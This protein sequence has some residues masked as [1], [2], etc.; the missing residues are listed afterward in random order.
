MYA[1][2]D[3]SV[4]VY[5]KTLDRPTRM[6]VVCA[7]DSM[8]LQDCT[9]DSAHYGLVYSSGNG[10][11]H[12]AD[13]AGAK[14]LDLDFHV[15]GITGLYVGL[16]IKDMLRNRDSL[17]LISDKAPQLREV[18]IQEILNAATDDSTPPRVREI[19]SMDASIQPVIAGAT[20]DGDGRILVA[21]PG[22]GSLGIWDGTS[23]GFWRFDATYLTDATELDCDSTSV[24][25]PGA[26]AAD[27]TLL[28]V[29]SSN[30]DDL[31]L[32][33]LS[34]CPECSFV[35][36]SSPGSEGWRSLAISPDT[37]AGRFVYAVSGQGDVR[38]FSVEDATECLVHPE[39]TQ[40]SS[41]T[42]DDPLRFCVPAGDATL[43]DTAYSRGLKPYYSSVV[44]DLTFFEVHP[45]EHPAMGDSLALDGVYAALLGSDGSI[46]IVNVY[47]NLDESDWSALYGPDADGRVWPSQVVSHWFHNARNWRPKGDGGEDRPMIEEPISYYIDNA[48]IIP[49]DS[50]PSL[51]PFPSGRYMDV[52]DDYLLYGET[53]TLIYEGV[54][55][56]TSRDFGIVDTS[57][58]TAVLVDEG[59]A[60]CSRG[61]TEGMVV[62]FTGCDSSEDCGTDEKCVR[63]PL[64]HQG[65]GGLCFPSDR[66]EELMRQCT[67][68]LVSDREFLVTS[69][70]DGR[71]GLAVREA[72]DPLTGS[73]R[74]CTSDSECS[75]LGHEQSAVCSSEGRCVYG[76]LADAGVCLGST[77]E[78][79]EIL[80][81]DG[82]WLYSSATPRLPDKIASPDGSCTDTD[83]A[84]SSRYIRVQD[85]SMT[86]HAGPLDV[87]LDVPD[88]RAVPWRY[89]VVFSVQPGYSPKVVN[90]GVTLPAGVLTSDDGFLYV[91]DE[92]E[93]TTYYS[94]RGRILRMETSNLSF[95]TGYSIH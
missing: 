3:D 37:P 81:G 59:G 56:G 8:R 14:P 83:R 91:L 66:A 61:V 68:L 55:P 82:F 13:L 22:C 27:G 46:Y 63:S 62:R 15:P 33:D 34:Q 51:V 28:A 89:K 39:M 72:V 36:M 71:L 35:Q 25:E 32:I 4:T 23:W 79:Y 29:A 53:W 52:H 54:V 11:I 49:D 75:D 16:G 76:E 7:D 60:F 21:L 48:A 12:L 84:V 20:A 64:Q 31:L 88:A 94:Y 17:V 67:G 78:H 87:L 73:V 43:P 10:F 86:V 44:R 65:Y 1:C 9:S 40:V 6:V 58:A 41:L 95:D 26:I 70:K 45:E 18:S 47:Q 42:P 57:G 5:T 85:G 50:Q 38:V 2:E 93:D 69:V 90:T 92:S 74:N 19:S 80:A 77:R 30:G 24:F